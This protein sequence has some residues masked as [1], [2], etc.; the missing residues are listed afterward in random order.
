MVVE[1]IKNAKNRIDLK[2]LRLGD[3]APGD[4]SGGY[5]FKFDQM[6]AEEPML[7]CTGS[8]LFSSGFDWGRPQDTETDSEEGTCWS[9][10]EVVDPVPLDPVQETWITE[11]IQTFHDALHE[12]PMGDIFSYIDISS[13]V[14]HFIINEL[15]RDV[16][17]YI[18]SSYYHKERDGLLK[19]GPL[20][21]Y[22]FS[23]ACFE[24]NGSEGDTFSPEGW[25]WEDGRRGTNDWFIL[26]PTNTDFMAAVSARWRTLRETF[27][28]D[29]EVDSR[30]D[31]I[32]APLANA[33]VRDLELWP[34]GSYQF[35]GGRLEMPDEPTWDGQI[36]VMRTWVHQRLTWLDG[37]L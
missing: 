34:V 35:M 29:A 3:T 36:E 30:I 18:R 5:I 1:T 12:E 19:A 26:L 37:Q 17:A 7:E 27:L 28:S 32:K 13:F 6:A 20:W 11:Y 15:S 2:Q 21:D 16:D 22:N 33:A 25:Q 8:P 23:L 10:F 14:D 4:L 9:D 24:G 31:R